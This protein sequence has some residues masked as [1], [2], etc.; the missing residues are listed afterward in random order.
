MVGVAPLAVL[1]AVFA[2]YVEG[3]GRM[4]EP[5]GRGTE[6]RKNEWP[7]EEAQKDYN[8]METYCGGKGVSFIM[9]TYLVNRS[10]NLFFYF[11]ILFIYLLR[12]SRSSGN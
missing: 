4:W 11:S 9:N 10:P 5:P 12:V 8:D 3:H 7:I 2:V 6:W 1:L